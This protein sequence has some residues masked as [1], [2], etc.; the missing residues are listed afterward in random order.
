MGAGILLGILGET[1]LILWIVTLLV[2]GVVIKGGKVSRRKNMTNLSIL[3][4]IL[5]AIIEIGQG[6][7]NSL[8]KTII[9]VGGVIVLLVSNEEWEE[10]E[11]KW[12]DY[13]Y[14]EIIML[15]ILG[16]MIMVSAKDMIMMYLGIET[17]SLSLYIMATLRKT[18]QYSTEAGLKYIILGAIGT[19]IILLGI[20][21]IYITTGT[22]EWEG[23]GQYTMVTKETGVELGA[24]MIVVAI[25][26]KLGVAPLHMWVPD[27]Y[28]GAPTVV[29]MFFAIVPKF[30]VISLLISLIS[31]PFVGMLNERIQPLI[32]GTAIIS[33]IV[34]SVGAINQTKIKRVLAYSAI[35]HMGW[36]I[37]GVG[38]GTV[39]GLQAGIIYMIIYMI[40]GITTFSIV[41]NEYAA[42]GNN[43]IIELSG[44]ARRSPVIAITMGLTLLSIAGVP[45]L[46]GFYSKYNVIIA[47][48]EENWMVVSGIGII[49]S[50]IGAYYY[51]RI[52]QIMYFNDSPAYLGKDLGDLVEPRKLKKEGVWRIG[53]MGGTLYIIMTYLIYPNPI[54]TIS[55][56]GLIKNIM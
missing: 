44:L 28:E 12:E 2:Y 51:I 53:I 42:T 16:M 52:I 24:L 1:Y 22:I 31:M 55:Y 47:L 19:G 33:I 18:G 32:I 9:L 45:P 43:Y 17:M 6:I 38:V 36:V 23:I 21:Q 46:A 25:L 54:I 49:V 56:E 50:V 30:A 34:G 20:S 4:L 7:T 8:I 41:L 27:V 5:T 11:G 13:E 40:M 29:T 39:W 26:F 10:R 3:V 37:L 48:L 15:A 35:A 14:N